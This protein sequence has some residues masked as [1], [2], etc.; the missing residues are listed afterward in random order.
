MIA[1]ARTSRR[2]PKFRHHKASGQGFVELDGRRK[3][4]GRFDLA[5]TRQKYHRAIAEW[6]ASG[7]QVRVGPGDIAIT[8]LITQFWRHVGQHYRKSDGTPTSE[9]HNFREAL[10]PLQRLYGNSKAADFGPLALKAVRQ[11][12]IDEGWARTTINKAVG[13]L[14]RMYRWA[15]ENELVPANVYHAVQCVSGLQAG[16]TEAQEPEPVQPV[17]DSVV[18]D[19]LEHLTPTVRAM[20]ALQRLTGMRPGEVCSLRGCDLDT[21]G[22]VWVYRPESH[23]TRHRGRQ[24]LIFIGPSGQDILRP[25][26]RRDLQAHFFKPAQSDAERRA[27]MHAARKTPLSCGNRPGSNRTRKPAKAPGDRY[28]VT[29]YR[30]AIIYACD[31]AFPP[32]ANVKSKEE[33]KQWRRS[34]HWHPNQLRHS[35]A[36]EIRRDHGLEAAQVL[37]GHAQA[38]VTQVYAERD[39]AKAIAVAMKVG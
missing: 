29:A 33:L 11:N 38:N 10:R 34:H 28:D 24:R 18:A 19:T 23:K 20:V 12:M 21:S 16:R 26:L 4:L 2:V 30:R 15:A 6:L 35:Y 37:L 8:E 5:E 27:A 13:R 1:K 32:P 25:F 3:Y 14:K 22:Q 39:I 31:R 9:V 17:S 7:R 36:T